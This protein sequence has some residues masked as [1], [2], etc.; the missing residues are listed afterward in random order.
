MLSADEYLD[1]ND[2]AFGPYAEVDDLDDDF[3]LDDDADD[4]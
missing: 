3:D 4:D 1:W 2:D